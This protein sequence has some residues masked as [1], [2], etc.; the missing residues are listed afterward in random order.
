MASS[1]D[2][3]SR[4]TTDQLASKP[5]GKQGSLGISPI[6]T[7]ITLVFAGAVI[8]IAL[9]SYTV[10]HH[11]ATQKRA[12]TESPIRQQPVL[13]AK[14][15]VKL[16]ST[17]TAD[18]TPHGL[19]PNKVP[20]NFVASQPSYEDQ[21]AKGKDALDSGDY[22]AAIVRFSKALE[23][24]PD[25][26]SAAD[27][28]A[29]AHGGRGTLRYSRGEF[30]S[31]IDDLLESIRYHPSPNPYGRILPLAY[32]ECL[33]RNLSADD[34]DKAILILSVA[35][36]HFPDDDDLK[37][38]LANAYLHRSYVRQKD[39]EFKEARDDWEHARSLRP[40]VPEYS[41]YPATVSLRR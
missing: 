22:N 36:T 27:Y 31:S 37:T 23:L 38:L 35:V 41:A 1:A 25:S 34:C 24:R 30:K 16:K 3:R 14:P 21:V 18:I 12:T 15:V 20:P 5:N 9:G 8:V 2:N 6:V 13:A 39:H 40:D 33:A 4:P 7:A 17:A 19:A 28:L 32:E 10:D 29:V 11:G 26:H